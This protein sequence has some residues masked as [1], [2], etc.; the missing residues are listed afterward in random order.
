MATKSQEVVSKAGIMPRLSLAEKIIK[1]GKSRG[2]KSTGKHIVKFLEDKVVKG[3]DFSTGQEIM[4]MKYIFE[5]NGQKKFY[6]RPLRDENEEVHYFIQRMSQFNYGDE[7]VIEYLQKGLKGYIS[8]NKNTGQ[9]DVS[10][11]GS[12]T[13]IAD[14]DIPVLEEDEDIDV[15]KIPF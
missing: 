9:P 14:E 15:D 8:V 2:T 1:N 13:D 5:E 11:E 3:K 4:K 7:L 12:G 10:Q 6:T